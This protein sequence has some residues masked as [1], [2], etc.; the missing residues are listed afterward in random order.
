MKHISYA[1]EIW[2]ENECSELLNDCQRILAKN[3][4]QL[5]CEIIEVFRT[6]LRKFS[7]QR[8]AIAYTFNI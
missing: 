3:V 2:R 5:H 7:L 1:E 6:I 8:N 4:I